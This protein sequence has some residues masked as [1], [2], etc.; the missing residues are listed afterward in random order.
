MFKVKEWTIVKTLEVVEE[1]EVSTKSIEAQIA[2]KEWLIK[3][4]T[5]QVEELKA[6]LK[7]VAKLEKEVK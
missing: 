4:L 3:K 7:E 5:A 6:D 1:V 2:S